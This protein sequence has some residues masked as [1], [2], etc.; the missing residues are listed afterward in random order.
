MLVGQVTLFPTYTAAFFTYIGLLE[1][2]SGEQIQQ[3][4]QAAFLPT[5]VAGSGF[6]PLVN[7]FNFRFVPSTHRVL[8]VNGCGLVWNA[9]LR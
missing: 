9:Y 4:F 7:I 5:M 2:C 1:G 8:Y 3:R 6:W